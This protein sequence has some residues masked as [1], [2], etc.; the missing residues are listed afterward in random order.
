MTAVCCWCSLKL[1][2]RTIM[3]EIK[4]TLD[5]VMQ[6][7]RHM[8]L[9][10]EERQAQKEEDIRKSLR[11][12]IQKYTDDLLRKEQF[13]KAFERLETLEDRSNRQLLLEECL[14]RIEIGRDC[15]AL[16]EVLDFGCRVDTRALADRLNGHEAKRQAAETERKGELKDMLENQWKISGSAVDPNLDSDSVFENTMHD[17]NDDYGERLQEEKNRLLA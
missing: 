5:L 8:T 16:L 9:S 4:S 12:L 17:L 2:K 6:K 14:D 3:G 10:R 15:K 1:D 11:G 7:T 13:L